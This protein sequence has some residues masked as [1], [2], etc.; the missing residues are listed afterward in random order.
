MGRCAHSAACGR[1]WKWEGQEGTGGQ[2]GWGDGRWWGE[3]CGWEGGEVWFCSW[4]KEEGW[5]YNRCCC[6]RREGKGGEEEEEER[7]RGLEMGYV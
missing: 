6:V 5:C 4:G 2:V 3:V 7:R 1:G